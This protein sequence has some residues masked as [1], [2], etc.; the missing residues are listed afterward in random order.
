VFVKASAILMPLS[1]FCVACHMATESCHTILTS[2]V[3]QMLLANS[4]RPSCGGITITNGAEKITLSK[5]RLRYSKFRF[6]VL[7]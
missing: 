6:S 2:E 1:Y 5:F 4:R 7:V 3:E